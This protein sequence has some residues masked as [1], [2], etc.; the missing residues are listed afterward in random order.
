M[1]S[2]T[3]KSISMP[4]CPYCEKGQYNICGHQQMKDWET[5]FDEL[6]SDAG[7]IYPNR[8]RRIKDFFLKEKQSL[9]LQIDEIVDEEYNSRDDYAV[10]IINEERQ[11]IREGLN[12]LKE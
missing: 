11:R 10:D 9:L 2:L 7:E 6:W 5:R 12:K 8:K 3:G 1:K 4:P